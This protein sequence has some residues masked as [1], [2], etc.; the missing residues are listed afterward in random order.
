MDGGQ[1]SK[2]W[3]RASVL[4][5]DRRHGRTADPRVCAIRWARWPCYGGHPAQPSQDDIRGKKE[6]LNLTNKA[7]MLMKTKGWE[8]EQSQTKPFEAGGKTP[9]DQAVISVR[10]REKLR[11]LRAGL[12]RCVLP[13]LACP[14]V[15]GTPSPRS[16]R[17]AGRL[18]ASPRPFPY[19]QNSRDG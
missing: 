11:T 19:N 14:P 15:S 3:R 6:C 12:N 17:F 8:N 16:G 13:F 18:V 4:R 10:P 1:R 2:G 9:Q 7:I 5:A